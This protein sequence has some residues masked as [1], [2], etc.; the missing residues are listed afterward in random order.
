MNEPISKSKML[1]EVPSSRAPV[2]NN[3]DDPIERLY[4]QPLSSTRTGALY[5]AFS[6]PTKIS[7]EAIAI[8]IATHT[9][10]GS[11]VLDAF[12]GSG[13]TGLAALL[14]DRPTDTMKAMAANMGVSPKWG[15]RRAHLF[16]IGTLGAFVSKT[17]CSPPDPE[18]FAKAAA[19]LVEK[20][21]SVLGSIYAAQSPDG[22]DGFLRHAIWSD[23]LAC[24]HCGEEISYW[25][26]AIRRS[27]LSMSTEFACVSCQKVSKIIDCERVME[28][29]VD[30]FGGSQLTRKKR[31]LAQVYGQS[32]KQK[33]QREPTDHDR[34][35]FTLAEMMPLPL[36]AP[37]KEINWGD[38]H[39]AGY[40]AGI[41][42]LH[43]F[44]TRRN[45]LV[46]S[47]LWE[48][49]N[50]FPEEMRSALRLLVLSYNSSHSTLMTRV[51]IK[52][53]LGDLV[54]TGAQSGVLYVSGLPV[55]K[56]IVEGIAR[57][58]KS[59]C[60]AF[61]L[62][63]GSRSSVVVHHGSSEKMDM[64]SGSVDYMFTDPPFGD[65]IPYAELNQINEL[66]LGVTTDRSKEI[67]VS[68][69]QDKGVDK[70]GYMMKS[71]F[72]ESARVLK[73]DGKATVVFHSAHSAIWRALV[74]AYTEAGFTVKVA[75]ILDKIQSSFKQVVSDVSVKGDPLL[76]LTKDAQVVF[77][78]NAESVA[79]EVLSE[80]R[81]DEQID[82]KLLW[83]QFVGRCLERGFD[84]PIEAKDFYER[85]RVTFD[86]AR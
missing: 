47:S 24:P 52:Q 30:E 42:R 23:I 69:A 77:S 73:N 34:T 84:M 79:N 68:K 27:P 2:G 60:N 14:C 59:F 45:F 43:H 17:M 41:S 10:P 54:L 12:G 66:W 74:G 62:L 46:M 72:S 6:Y 16:E 71:V 48:M 39:R 29:V 1:G 11:T 44:Y 25:A 63:R 70:Y 50:E 7:P 22:R 4:Q 40:H 20:A 81:I 76:L 36:L 35:V 65:Y 56:N 57:K 55:E 13:T 83:S 75:S 82:P 15:P 3:I 19:S 67:I 9:E 51:V 58:A 49:V 28:T 86:E 85:V 38:L 18:I 5:N 64:P 8:F 61:E 37:N 32:G 53:G 31:V 33:W 78:G 80:A 21:R 26:A